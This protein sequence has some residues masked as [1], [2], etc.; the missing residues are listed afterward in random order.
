M[1]VLIVALA[2]VLQQLFLLLWL[3]SILGSV[4]IIV[5]R[6]ST[7]TNAAKS[8]IT[9][10]ILFTSSRFNT[11][12]VTSTICTTFMITVIIT[13]TSISV[14]VTITHPSFIVRIHINMINTIDAIIVTLV[15][16][17]IIMNVTIVTAS[18]NASL[19]IPAPVLL[20]SLLLLVRVPSNAQ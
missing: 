10:F 12:A 13:T 2:V 1:F 4:Q 19:S 16:N 17:C 15:S 3:V 8:T 11:I 14:A 5:V 6:T 9:T 18:N 7:S 20:L